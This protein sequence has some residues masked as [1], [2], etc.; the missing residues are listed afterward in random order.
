MTDI[1]ATHDY[2]VR[3]VNGVSHAL[4]AAAVWT[5]T[6]LN[7]A[8]RSEYTCFVRCMPGSA[9]AHGVLLPEGE[10]VDCVMCLARG[11]P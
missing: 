6:R 3:D 1:Y 10:P 4:R 7:A 5:R 2:V 9:L 11:D 8:L